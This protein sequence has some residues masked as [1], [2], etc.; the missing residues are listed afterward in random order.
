MTS[1][2]KGFAVTGISIKHVATFSNVEPYLH[3]S[4]QHYHLYYTL[5]FKFFWLHDIIG[6]L[7]ILSY[8]R[9]V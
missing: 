6:G 4:V 8:D 1:Y 2:D 7:F 9:I 3:F 5:E